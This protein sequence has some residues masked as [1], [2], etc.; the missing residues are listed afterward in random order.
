MAQYHIVGQG[1]LII[2]A[3]RSHSDTQLSVGILWTSDKPDTETSTKKKNTQHSQ[4]T[5][6]QAPGGTRT[7]NPI[8]RG[9][10]APGLKPRG[11]W[12]RQ[13]MLVYWML[14]P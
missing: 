12:V 7:H 10:T 8:K 1:L 11:H 5:D 6:I 14:I 2:Q 3:S 13:T 9:T 4:E